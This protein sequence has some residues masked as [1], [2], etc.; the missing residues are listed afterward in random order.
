[1]LV[2]LE[3]LPAIEPQPFPDR[4]AALHRRIERAD[5]RLIAV[6]QPAVDVH[7]QIAVLLVAVPA[8]GLLF[9]FVVAERL[10]IIIVSALAT[11]AAW[12]WMFERWGMLA[13]FPYPRLDAAFL[14][15]AMRGAMAMLI[16][17]GGVWLAKGLVNR[18]IRAERIPGRDVVTK[19]PAGPT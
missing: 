6:N 9:R 16:V 17:A 13:K 11:H 2:E 1:M 19:M 15:S 5:P 8:L 14:A 3:Y 7:Q 12:Q 10:G 4:V 18:W